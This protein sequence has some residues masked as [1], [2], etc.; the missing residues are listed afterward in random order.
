MATDSGKGD[1]VEVRVRVLEE[2]VSDAK[3]WTKIA[4]AVILGMFGLGVFQLP[5]YIEHKARSVADSAAAKEA[6]KELT[7]TIKNYGD[8]AKKALDSVVKDQESSTRAL[9]SSE[10]A[11]AKAESLL[12]TLEG[13]K[14]RVEDQELKFDLKHGL[15]TKNELTFSFEVKHCWYYSMSNDDF[16]HR[17][18]IKLTIE[19][20]KVRV[21]TGK[22]Q[23]RVLSTFENAA[24]LFANAPEISIRVFATNF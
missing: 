16:G 6:S 11:R 20:S 12:A 24:E 1:S 23:S 18:E 19:G 17:V 3:K 22:T 13:A 21:D 5:A 14:P 2:I 9:K 4:G 7:D 8:D 15:V 10:D